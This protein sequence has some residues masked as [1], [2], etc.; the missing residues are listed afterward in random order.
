MAV[1]RLRVNGRDHRVDV[2]PA[3]PLL[4]V[5]R[6]E[7]GLTGAKYGCGEGQ[8]GACT[9]LVD[10]QAVR[11]CVAPVGTMTGKAI[12]TVEGLAPSSTA[13]HRVQQAFAEQDAM[14]C[15]YCTTGMIMAAVALLARQP[16]PTEEQVVRGMNGNI[17][18]CGSHPRIVAAI[19]AAASATPSAQQGPTNGPRPD[20]EDTRRGTR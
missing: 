6:T 20:P 14:Q 13:M 3:E 7:L 15:G 18:R 1:I 10:G 9:V 16:N 19:R 2:P 8:C 5:L 17:C 12:T 4:T 11:S